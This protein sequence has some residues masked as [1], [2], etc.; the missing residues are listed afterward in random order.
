PASTTAAARRR[1]S[2]STSSSPASPRATIGWLVTTASSKPASRRRAS[3]AAVAG[4][5]CTAARSNEYRAS[6]TRT[7]SRS[8]KPAGRCF[9]AGDRRGI[10]GGADKPPLSDS[11]E[12][13]D[14]PAANHRLDRVE[15]RVD[16]EAGDVVA[17]DEAVVA[18]QA[19]PLGQLRRASGDYPAVAP[20]VQVL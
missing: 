20:D 7:P 10:S 12:H 17:V 8:R 14:Q 6:L 1:C 16:A 2:S 3:A 4:S 18:V 5:S 9:A 13:A 19:Q 11:V 15:A